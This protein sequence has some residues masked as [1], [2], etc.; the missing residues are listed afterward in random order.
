[1]KSRKT[2]F[3]G[4]LAI[5]FVFAGYNVY[6]YFQTQKAIQAEEDRQAEET[7]QKRIAEAERKE[8]ERLAR[9]EAEKREAE[10]QRLAREA[11]E[12][13]RQRQAEAERLAREA[14]AEAQRQAKEAARIQERTLKARSLKHI[15]GLPDET[16]SKLRQLS[17]AYIRS[18]PD[19]F[20]SRSFS[21]EQ[22][23]ASRQ[24]VKLMGQGTTPLMLYAAI[25]DDLDV[26][27]ALLDVGNDLNAQNQQGYT[28]L[29]FAAAYSSPEVIDF[30]IGQG[31][32]TSITAHVLSLNALH[33]GSLFNPHPAS[34]RSLVQAG[35]PLE[36]KSE[37]DYTALLLA[38]S[39]NPNLEV[40]EELAKLGADTSFTDPE[41][42]TAHR[43]VQLRIDGEGDRYVKISDAV[44]ERVLEA[45]N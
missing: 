19:E 16:I 1:M 23:G 27:Q 15:E 8:A 39:D 12:E 29:M 31:A 40:A 24:F 36:G 21:A 7:R 35:L 42:R 43:L 28:A 10:E 37:N 34:I 26:L 45:L 5:V 20:R 14:E 30:L 17:A 38:A 22:M 25:S 3:A 11:A 33:I 13:E 41:G 44:D 6:S 9:I 32:D 18:N 2:I 4:L